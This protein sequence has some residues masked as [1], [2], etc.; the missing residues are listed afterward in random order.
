MKT[1]LKDFREILWQSIQKFKKPCFIDTTYV[2]VIR[3]DYYAYGTKETFQ[4]LA[5]DLLENTRNIVSVLYA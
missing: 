3:L 4:Y 2:G 1:F 5:S